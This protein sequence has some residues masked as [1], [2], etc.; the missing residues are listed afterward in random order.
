MEG[1]EEGKA[2]EADL[3]VEVALAEEETEGVACE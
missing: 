3:E 1:E 2:E